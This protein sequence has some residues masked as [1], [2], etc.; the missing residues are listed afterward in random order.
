MKEHRNVGQAEDEQIRGLKQLY[1]KYHLESDGFF[2]INLNE[3][4]Q[5]S[6]HA[7]ILKNFDIQIGSNI[8][9]VVGKY[10]YFDCIFGSALNLARQNNFKV[11]SPMPSNI[12]SI[13]I[14]GVNLN[15]E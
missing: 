11:S 1:L 12:V 10:K 4:A 15:I 8:L 6:N 3:N 9:D 7:R 13:L 2:T 14:L 5:E